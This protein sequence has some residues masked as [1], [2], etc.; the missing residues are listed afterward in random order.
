MT[1]IMLNN[2]CVCAGCDY[3]CIPSNKW[4]LIDW[5]IDWSLDASGC[6]SISGVHLD[7]ENTSFGCLYFWCFHDASNLNWRIMP[8]FYV[9]SD[10]ACNHFWCDAVLLGSGCISCP[11]KCLILTS[12]YSSIHVMT[13]TLYRSTPPLESIRWVPSFCLGCVF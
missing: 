1:V 13:S 7:V 8:E 12:A 4:I 5:L 10:L 6:W 3:L 2:N 9:W 11:T